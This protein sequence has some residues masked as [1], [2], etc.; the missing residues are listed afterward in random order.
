MSDQAIS[1]YCEYAK[2]GKVVVFDTETT[3]VGASDEVCQ[4]AAVEYERG[5]RARS[6]NEYLRISFPMPYY[7]ESI[8]GISDEFLAEHGIEPMEGLSRFFELVKGDALL[9]AHNAKFDIRMIAGTCAKNGME[10]LPE[11]VFVCDTWHLAKKVV[12]GL[13]N[14]QLATLIDE[15]HVDA[16]NSHDAMDD[17]L[18]CAGVFFHLVDMATRKGTRR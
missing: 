6:L 1:R 10:G 9:V 4:I 16:V 7:A 5:V 15:F 17:V 18:G 3:G 14:Y 11:D 13:E 12:P 2:R 8:H